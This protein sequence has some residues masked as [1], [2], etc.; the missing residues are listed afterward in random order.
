VRYYKI[1]PWWSKDRPAAIRK[2][3]ASNE[4]LLDLNTIKKLIN[5]A[6]KEFEAMEL[7]GGEYAKF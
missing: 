3:F 4:E 1:H 5:R 6:D 7:R 2:E